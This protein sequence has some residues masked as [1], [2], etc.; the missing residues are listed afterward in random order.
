ML[1]KWYFHR[2]SRLLKK[3]QQALPRDI[4]Y[5]CITPSDTVWFRDEYKWKNA[6]F[7]PA[8]TPF[9]KVSGIEGAGNFCLYHGNLAVPENEQ[10]AVWLLTR[11]FPKIKLPLV[12]AGRKPSRRLDKLAHLC[13]HTCLVADP[14]ETEINDLVRKAHI[15]VLP[16]FSSTGIKLK[17]LQA[18]FEGRH[19]VTNREMVNGTGLEDACHIASG[20]KAFASVIMQLHHREFGEEELRLRT[21]LLGET[22]NNDVNVR[23]LI[24]YLW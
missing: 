15:N 19:C 24:A 6:F 12:I 5:A 16:S 4:P 8:F 13:Q 17:L 3:Y 7:L 21:R 10:A 9:N 18:L 22:Y 2:E 1:K 23:A 20:S 11:V 14:S